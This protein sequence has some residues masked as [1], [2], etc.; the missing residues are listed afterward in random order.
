MKKYSYLLIAAMFLLSW[1]N[2]KHYNAPL[3]ECEGGALQFDGVDDYV[4]VDH[5]FY[6]FTNQ[7]TVE[8]WANIDPSTGDGSGIGQADP[9]QDDWNTNVWLMY[10]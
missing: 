7:I 2:H 3:S 9:T 6:E 1:N 8:W 5:P 10:G 4:R